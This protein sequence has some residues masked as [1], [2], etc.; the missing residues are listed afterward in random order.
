MKLNDVKIGSMYEM[1]VS[2]RLVR[3][4]VLTETLHRTL[5]GYRKGFTALN[6]TTNR[7][8]NLRS[9][10]RLRPLSAMLSFYLDVT[11]ETLEA[12]A[13]IGKFIED[14]AKVL[15]AFSSVTKEITR[16]EAVEL[17]HETIGLG[18]WL[19]GLRQARNGGLAI[20]GKGMFRACKT[21]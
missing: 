16:A 13:K 1:K 9:A 8:L 11:K 6:L 10:A 18:N 4:R 14:P 17:V 7:V 19:D 20:P 15:A 3:V 21:N 5:S 2:G 12:T